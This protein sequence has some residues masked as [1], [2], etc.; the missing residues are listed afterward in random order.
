MLENPII[1]NTV[2][3]LRPSEF[4]RI[5]DTIP[6]IDHKDKFEAL[7]Y[8]G[9]RYVELQ[10]LY[11]HKDAFQ[12]N[13]ILMPSTKPEARHKQRYIRLNANGIRAVT[14]FL[15]SKHN[16]PDYSGWDENLIRWAKKAGLDT[17]GIC[18]KS[19]RKT[20]ESWLATMYPNNFQQI[21]LSQGHTERV[22]MEY[23][24]MLPFQ[25]MD[26]VDMRFYTDGWI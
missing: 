19:T 13:T 25:E 18:C 20:W 24:L 15:R 23:Y 9:C 21:F 11:K 2:R 22:S 10:W 4:K 8:T 3:I 12:G 17:R 1:K 16:L 26:K 7:L 5:Y 6:K 14:Y